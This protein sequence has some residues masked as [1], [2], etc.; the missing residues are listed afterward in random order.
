MFTISVMIF[1]IFA[2][3]WS[4]V[5][6]MKK[7]KEVNYSSGKYLAWGL[8]LVGI[9]IFFYAARTVIVQFGEQYYWADQYLLYRPGTF[10]HSIGLFLA[11]L[12]VYKEFTPKLFAKIT[13][14]PVLG[15]MLYLAGM[16]AIA[17]VT[18]GIKTAPLEPFKMIITN[19]PWTSPK[20]AQIFL[21]IT[22]GVPFI[23]L[24]IFLYNALKGNKLKSI[25]YGVGIPILGFVGM[26]GIWKPA[27][28]PFDFAKGTYLGIF[29]AAIILILSTIFIARERKTVIKALLYGL[30]IS[31]QGLFVPL[32][33]FISPIFARLGY[34]IGALLVYKAFGMKTE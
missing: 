23:I 9:A 29:I 31:F 16:F 15:S 14:I 19:Y 30:G 2:L 26:I 8:I 10:I 20:T 7:S 4:G 17:K 6:I 21:F 12:F 11:F 1:D 33:I 13:S 28:L 3:I 22:I 18:R 5:R 34:G 24:G 27:F 32:C 25:L